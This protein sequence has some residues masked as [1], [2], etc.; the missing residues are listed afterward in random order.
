MS[1]SAA[2]AVR[3]YL[4]SVYPAAKQRLQLLN[5]QQL[6]RHFE[7]LDYFYSTSEAT[8]SSLRP[9]PNMLR[10]SSGIGAALPYLPAGAFYHAVGHAPLDGG[11]FNAIQWG[12]Y[13][14]HTHPVKLLP[15][16]L[17]LDK[18]SKFYSS[19]GARIGPQPSWTSPAAIVRY[20][21]YPSGLEQP[22]QTMLHAANLHTRALRKAPI[23]SIHAYPF[24]V[25]NAARVLRFSELRDG[26][27]LEVELWGGL[28]NADE[29]PPICG[30]WANLWSGTGLF[31][32]VSYPFVSLSKATALL[33]LFAALAARNATGLESVVDLVGARARVQAM[34]TRDASSSVADCLG[35]YMLSMLPRAGGHRDPSFSALAQRWE[36]FAARSTPRDL[37]SKTLH[38]VGQGNVGN[39][40]VLP[41]TQA[42]RFAIHWTFGINGKGRNTP[43]WRSSPIGPDG[44]LAT[45]ACMLGHKTVVLTAAANDNGLLHQELVDFEVPEPLGWPSP[46]GG[47][48]TNDAHWCLAQPFAFVQSDAERGAQAQRLRRLQ[49][50]SFWRQIGKFRLPTDLEGAPGRP[51]LPCDISFG[52]VHDPDNSAGAGELGACRGPKVR[53]PRPSAAKSCWAWCNGTAASMLSEL[54]L[55]H[56]RHNAATG[57]D[58]E[59]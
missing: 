58:D 54:S 6:L 18:S 36:T 57:I 48:P 34:R 24:D 13:D 46:I 38:L 9:H 26:D 59:S 20:V 28:L 7:S 15:S 42:Q 41:F 50:Q 52:S 8:L 14:R 29:C 21:H 31:L 43:F 27:L 53:V 2:D 30:T 51:S 3:S 56:V 1:T 4:E 49:M 12:S 10:I 17:A 25:V 33:E 19:F 47:R 23:S 11:R 55:G 44:L 32:K 5:E 40:A 22:P 37:V 16:M 39:T 45:L 35:A